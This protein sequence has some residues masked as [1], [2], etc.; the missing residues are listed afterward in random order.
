MFKNTDL[1]ALVQEQID[2]WR[3]GHHP[4]AAAFLGQHPELSGAKS[5]A[6]DLIYEEYCLRTESGD[7]I[8]KS[9]FCDQFP[10]YRQSIAKMIEVQEYLDQC[11]QFTAPPRE[12]Q[13]P[14]PGETFLGYEI[15]EPLGRGSLA[16][17]YLAREPALGKRLVVVKVSQFGA[18]EAQTLGRLSHENIVPIHSVQHDAASGWTAICMPLVGTATGVD[19]LDAAAAARAGD[20]GRF[21]ARVAAGARPIR[22]ASPHEAA[23]DKRA[24]KQWQGTFGDAI[25]RLGLQL[26]DG[27]QAAH[28]QG[29]VHRDLKPS[30]VLLAWS[31]RPML[32]DFNLA[33]DLEAANQRIG[34]TLAYMA[35][36][37]IAG[38]ARNQSEPARK[39]DPRTDV[40]SLGVV[41]YELLTG[42][43]PVR[44]DNAD[45]LP[46]DSY[47]PWLESKQHSPQSIRS[48]NPRVDPRL[49]Q[50]VL[51]CLAFDPAAR[52]ASAAELAAELR[53]YLSP[54]PAARRFANRNRRLLLA[55][56]VAAIA[57]FAA[58]AAYVGSRPS[59]QE[60]AFSRALAHLENGNLP[61]AEGL[62]SE[63]RRRW[64]SAAEFVFARAQLYR[65]QEHWP[66]A[67]AEYSAL[68]EIY[69]GVGWAMAGAC[70][71]KM[72]KY[73][74]ARFAFTKSRQAGDDHRTF[75]LM[76]A[77]AA[78][79]AGNAQLGEWLFS[80]VIAQNPDDFSA[81]R[82]RLEAYRVMA[83]SRNRAAKLNESAIEDAAKMCELRPGLPSARRDAIGVLRRAARDEDA[84]TRAGDEIR[85][86]MTRLLEGGC[87]RGELES[88]CSKLMSLFPNHVES[89]RTG[90]AP[91][92]EEPL[93]PD[94]PLPSSPQYDAFLRQLD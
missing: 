43:L 85:L 82:G 20:D 45:R 64:P 76:G 33:T 27:L 74:D 28:A 2:R 90:S 59:A 54:A 42:Q 47:Q 16:R 62:L 53:G 58:A 12:S 4:D 35:P 23:A 84:L 65:Q 70:D 87:T 9:T 21:V 5:L 55:A 34:G 88:C 3:S 26:A 17:V 10:A 38:L 57:L 73:E 51:K 89:R 75:R 48:H 79:K 52:Y 39:F 92:P 24:A 13:W 31:G 68:A 22:V 56:A 40:Y 41:L 50:A 19:L 77:Y 1:Q 61:A 91:A 49:D 6:L 63:G 93:I 60:Q 86:C 83:D 37:Q 66:E 11:P 71:L 80:Q 30:N 29:V 15:A 67:R 69:P 8:L 78:M 81:R 18:G 14:R 32:L 44:P 46:L 94:L 25:A 36:E 72:R 7:T